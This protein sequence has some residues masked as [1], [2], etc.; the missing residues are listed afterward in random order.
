MLIKKLF[1][2]GKL[3]TNSTKREAL[4]YIALMKFCAM[5]LILRW[6]LYNWERRTIDLGARMTEFLFISSGF[7]VGYNYYQREMPATYEA[8][9]KY[10]Y[11]HL[12][13]FYPLH[14]INSIYSFFHLRVKLNLTNYQ[15]LI[16]NFLMLKVWSSNKNYALGFNGISW[17]VSILLFLYFLSP[18]LLQGIKTL[19]KSLIIFVFVAITR[20]GIE[21]LIIKGSLNFMDFNFHR[22]PII[23]A[24]DFYLGMLVIPLFIEIK[25]FLDVIQN[26]FYVIYL[27]TIIQLFFPVVI[28][29]IISEYSNLGRKFFIFIFTAS[30]FIIGFD[31][32][33]ITNI[34]KKEI[35]QKIM[36]CQMEMYLLHPD[37]NAILVKIFKILNKNWPKNRELNFLIKF[38]FVFINSYAYKKYLRNK[39]AVF[40]DKIVDLFKKIFE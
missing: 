22:G 19:K 10:A 30:T 12:R 3:E 40:M 16:L 18:L 4:H 34:V 23:R 11:K 33:I 6:H 26:K 8:S 13:L 17:F 38:L 1:N 28:Y 20:Y 39:L 36:S 25:N 24:M 9:F 7:L 14:F 31:Y 29:Y 37:L 5:I 32:G 2:Y 35:C 21:L 27:F 15:M